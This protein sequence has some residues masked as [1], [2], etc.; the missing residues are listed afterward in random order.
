MK[1]NFKDIKLN[2]ESK[3]ISRKEWEE[4]FKQETGKSVKEV[5]LYKR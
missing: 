2:L 3:P 4:K 5:A 1:P